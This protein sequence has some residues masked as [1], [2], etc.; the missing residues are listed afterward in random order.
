MTRK[1]IEELTDEE[2][3]ELYKIIENYEF[4]LEKEGGQ[5]D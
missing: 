4:Y 1:E 3:I 5:N 2:L